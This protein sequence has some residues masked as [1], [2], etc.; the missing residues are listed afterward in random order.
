[1]ADPATIAA[2]GSLV[3]QAFKKPPHQFA[4]PTL[5]GGRRGS[6]FTAPAYNPPPRVE[7]SAVLDAFLRR[8]RQQPYEYAVPEYIPSPASFSTIT[9][10]I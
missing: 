10:P 1:M 9:R 4:P 8:R 7:T 2:I 5:G 6:A 3:M